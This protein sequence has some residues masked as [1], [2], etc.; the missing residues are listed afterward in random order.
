VAGDGIEA[1]VETVIEEGGVRKVVRTIL[2]GK[3]F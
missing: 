3:G 2:I 1:R